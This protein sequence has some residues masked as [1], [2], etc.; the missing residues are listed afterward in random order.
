M[1]QYY[2][3]ARSEHIETGAIL[4]KP[5]GM[6]HSASRPLLAQMTGQ[7]CAHHIVSGTE[8][9][10]TLV[11]VIISSMPPS[12]LPEL[13]SVAFHRASG[14][15]CLRVFSKRISWSDGEGE[16]HYSWSDIR[17]HIAA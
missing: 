13:L 1:Q 15:H 8:S 7:D 11:T 3:K 14:T 2:V 17:V 12:P 10:R 6:S 16:V 4:Q 9:H 5:S